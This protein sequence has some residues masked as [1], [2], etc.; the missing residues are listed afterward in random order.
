MPFFLVRVKNKQYFAFKLFI[1]IETFFNATKQS[2]KEEEAKMFRLF[3]A[4]S[5]VFI[6][7][8]YAASQNKSTKSASLI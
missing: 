4:L 7:G 1:C 6:L 2:G 5:F 3:F 8:S